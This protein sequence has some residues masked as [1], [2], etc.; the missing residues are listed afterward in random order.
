MKNNAHL[1]T[2]IIKYFA[3]GMEFILYLLNGNMVQDEPLGD[4]NNAMQY[5][6]NLPCHK[7]QKDCYFANSASGST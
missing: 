1:T 5:S 2:L 3:A 6:N 4:L 7:Q